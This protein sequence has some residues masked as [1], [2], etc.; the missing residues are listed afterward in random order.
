MKIILVGIIGNDIRIMGQN[1]GNS[2]QNNRYINVLSIIGSAL[3]M[4]S[5]NN[6]IGNANDSCAVQKK[7][8]SSSHNIPII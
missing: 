3:T 5:L 8:S 7:F 6:N 4:V 2:R 1:F